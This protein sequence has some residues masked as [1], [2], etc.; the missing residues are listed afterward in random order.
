LVF[1]SLKLRELFCLSLTMIIIDT[2]C[3]FYFS[4]S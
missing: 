1:P 3:L 4:K 2:L